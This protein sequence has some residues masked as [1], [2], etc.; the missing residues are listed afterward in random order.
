[1]CLVELQLT[2]YF[3][4]KGIAGGMLAHKQTYSKYTISRKYSS[5]ITPFP[6]SGVQTLHRTIHN[7]MYIKCNKYNINHRE[8]CLLP[9]ASAYL[10][11]RSRKYCIILYGGRNH[12]NR[13][14]FEK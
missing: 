1:M 14:W 4:S 11:N 5:S 3:P 12:K 7:I 8:G 6:I 10:G 13:L 9:G 2:R